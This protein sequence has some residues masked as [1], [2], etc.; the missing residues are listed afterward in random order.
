M[1]VD[2]RVL[3]T[4]TWKLNY[5]S[6]SDVLIKVSHIHFDARRMNLAIWRVNGHDVQQFDFENATVGY[7]QFMMRHASFR[8]P[9]VKENLVE[10]AVQDVG[11]EDHPI[12]VAQWRLE[13]APTWATMPRATPMRFDPHI[14]AAQ[15]AIAFETVGDEEQRQWFANHRLSIGFVEDIYAPTTPPELFPVLHNYNQ[16]RDYLPLVDFSQAIVTIP[17]MQTTT[18][19]TTALP[20]LG[21]RYRLWMTEEALHGNQIDIREWMRYAHNLS[22]ITTATTTPQL[23]HDVADARIPVFLTKPTV[24]VLPWAGM[25]DGVPRAV[26]II[27]HRFLPPATPSS[28]LRVSH[29]AAYTALPSHSD[30]RWD[31]V[32]DKPYWEDQQGIWPRKEVLEAITRIAVDPRRNPVWLVNDVRRFEVAI[33]LARKY[34]ATDLP[35]TVAFHDHLLEIAPLE[36][37]AEV[38]RLTLAVPLWEKFF[39]PTSVL[40]AALKINSFISW[41]VTIIVPLEA[42]S[43]RDKSFGSQPLVVQF[44]SFATS[45]LL[46]DWQ[47]YKAGIVQR[48]PLTTSQMPALKQHDVFFGKLGKSRRVATDW[49]AYQPWSFFDVRAPEFPIVA[50]PKP[51]PW[52]AK[53]LVNSPGWNYNIREDNAILLS[54][55][56]NQPQLPL[57]QWV[58]QEGKEDDFTL[59]LNGL[60]EHIAYKGSLRIWRE[61]PTTLTANDYSLDLVGVRNATALFF[62]RD[63]VQLWLEYTPRQAGR[64]S[65]SLDAYID[66]V[67]RAR[68][69]RVHTPPTELGTIVPQ[70]KLLIAEPPVALDPVVKAIQDLRQ[71]MTNLSIVATPPAAPAPT[72]AQPPPA[73]APEPPEVTAGLMMMKK[74]SSI[75]SLSE[76]TEQP[77]DLEGWLRDVATFRLDDS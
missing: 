44:G 29:P 13:Y 46:V 34:D 67:Y 24:L 18:E 35:R 54:E 37:P 23:L 47:F 71:Q 14:D 63:T 32:P 51:R 11:V 3:Y 59:T 5:D 30:A 64:I 75:E 52:T 74:S 73:R 28:L 7:S 41:P 2:E 65:T 48:I 45:K 4:R 15:Y 72:P 20:L 16:T 62:G 8:V 21:S 70:A 10:L 22:D 31:V 50:N 9:V 36:I 27:Y 42:K 43:M 49:P 6:E 17:D 56:S 77:Y 68:W 53:R 33:A 61:G 26:M 69:L 55:F 76:S 57:L 38:R 66:P 58:E 19:I 25:I 40:L 12:V 60:D 39:P 1:H